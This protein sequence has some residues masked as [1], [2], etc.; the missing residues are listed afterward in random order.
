MGDRHR[1]ER[2]P[3]R[4]RQAGLAVAGVA[5]CLIAAATPATTGAA[6]PPA[7]TRPPAAAG[8]ALDGGTLYASPGR[9]SGESPLTL[10]YGWER[11]DVGPTT[12]AAIAGAHSKSY[13]L[14]GADV[15]ATVRVAVT[16]VDRRGRSASAY[17]VP[18]GVVGRA[19]VANLEAP[20]LAGVAA[21]GRTL[22][23]T[24]GRW[25]AEGTITF[26]YRW[27]RCRA[28]GSLCVPVPRADGATYTVRG[29]DLERRLRARVTA[30]AGV[31]AS[32]GDSALSAVVIGGEPA[33][34]RPFPRV[35]IRGYATAAGAVFRL[36]RL[37]SPTSAQVDV[38][39]HGPECPF[40]H[41]TRRVR[42]GLEI[43]ALE[44]SFSA[45]TRLVFR[46][47]KEGRIG[48]YTS[49]EIRRL[50]APERHDRCLMRRRAEPMP[51][52]P[53]DR[54]GR[55]PSRPF[56]PRAADL[57]SPGGWRAANKP[58]VCADNRSFPCHEAA[59]IR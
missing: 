26:A 43:R 55:A 1:R 53:A 48:K 49:V 42:G 54:A 5:A 24:R 40:D 16:V 30:A 36:V 56:S 12:C 25:R 21:V 35:R 8:A 7:N 10:R 9:W 13:V 29:A 23:A 38:T 28:N 20:A 34:L 41:E 57:S 58:S 4:V 33:L 2:E 15:G 45:G 27:L 47:W 17:S 11:C 50:A 22:V 44:R 52:P 14:V 18:T 6:A 19:Q 32:T 37:S 59:R 39:C 3:A 51:C 31:A 46:I